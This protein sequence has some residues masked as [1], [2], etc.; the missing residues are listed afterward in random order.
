[1]KK[2]AL[3][4]VL[5]LM[6]TAWQFVSGTAEEQGN[7]NQYRPSPKSDSAPVPV[8]DSQ[9]MIFL[10]WICES[11]LE[12]GP[13]LSGVLADQIMETI[14]ATDEP[15]ETQKTIKQRYNETIKQ[16]CDEG[17]L[18]ILSRPQMMVVDRQMGFIHVGSI[19]ENEQKRGL[20]LGITPRIWNDRI[21]TTIRLQLDTRDE[22]DEWNQIQLNTVVSLQDG[23]P[24]V[25]G[26]LQT[27][28]DSD[29]PA[30][31]LF[32]YVEALRVSQRPLVSSERT[33]SY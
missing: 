3:C 14:S 32:L 4:T 2:A 31:E 5:V 15:L 7:V 18:K 30:K 28:S 13:L 21:L 9:Q 25:V 16:F 20:L 10:V 24:F 23:V 1:M 6:F 8:D 11:S 26:G 29:A 22:Q 27:R 33:V 17:K 12:N 19:D